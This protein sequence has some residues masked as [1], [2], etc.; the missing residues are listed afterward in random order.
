MAKQNTTSRTFGKCRIEEELGR[1]AAS[2]VY[3]GYHESFQ[4]PVAV[5]VV[6]KKEV[7][8]GGENSSWRIMREAR[9]A[10]Q[11]THPHIVRIYDCG[12]T[13]EKFYLAMEYI[14]GETC[15]SKLDR[16]GPFPW[17][18]AVEL[19]LQ[20]IDGLRHALRKNIIH[21]DIK[22]ENIMLDTEGQ[23][24]IAD[25]G[26]AKEWMPG[27]ASGTVQGEVLGTPY[28]MSPEQVRTPG[29]VDF[30]SDVY[31]IGA[32][33]YH[34]VT[35][36]PPFE[37]DSPFQVMTKQ[38]SMPSPS[39]KERNPDLPDPLCRIIMRM[40]AKAPED[41]YQSYG[42]L[43]RDL[44]RLL[45]GN[46]QDDEAKGDSAPSI[47][48]VRAG[49]VPVAKAN[50]RAKAM[51]LGALMTYAVFITYL[52]H[53][54]YVRTGLA[55]A[56]AGIVVLLAISAAWSCLALWDGEEYGEDAEL[57]DSFRTKV[58]GALNSLCDSLFLPTPRVYIPSR[59][60]NAHFSYS[61]FSP[62]ASLD[63]P[64]KW[65][66]ETGIEA[67]ELRALLAQSL[68]G[69]VSGDSHLRTLLALPLEAVKIG[70]SLTWKLAGFLP[71]SSTWR[72][73]VARVAA[74][75]ACAALLGGIGLLFW[76]HMSAG[77]LASLVIGVVLLCA[78]FERA[79]RHG[80]DAFAAQVL[81]GPQLV[82]FVIGASTPE[83]EQMEYVRYYLGET[84]LEEISDEMISE[85]IPAEE[86]EAEEEEEESAEAED[87]SETEPGS[88][89]SAAGK[90]SFVFSKNA[91]HASILDR[92][93]VLFSP[94][95]LAPERVNRL[96]GMGETR[97]PFES[98]LRPI[99]H[100][101][102]SRLSPGKDKQ[103]MKLDDLG[104]VRFYAIL[105]S[106]VGIIAAVVL[107]AI[108]RLSAPHYA[109]LLTANAVLAGVFGVSLAG[110]AYGTN[111]SP[112]RFVW[113]SAVTS[114]FFACVSA[115]MLCMLGGQASGLAAIQVPVSFAM[116]SIGS[117][118]SG[119]ALTRVFS[120]PATDTRSESEELLS[121]I[122]HMK[123]R[124][125]DGKKSAKN[126]DEKE[127]KTREKKST[128]KKARKTTGK[129]QGKTSARKV[130]ATQGRAPAARGMESA[131]RKSG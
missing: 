57:T 44:V 29:E 79:S 116:V 10:A 38:V 60:D 58:Q 33:L 37:G 86:V 115:L 96:S 76:V 89:T 81:G 28:Y 85:E 62:K 27:R 52:Y 122:S 21:R 72:V 66:K 97:L 7:E 102:K 114:A 54:L 99:W 129:K 100:V 46:T 106:T 12:E 64:S 128:G 42:K 127:S 4:I 105:G 49:Q 36:S 15:R 3:R 94:L 111:I 32:T 19:V 35:G 8:R 68:G 24:R 55:G 98:L 95:P 88:E 17:R 30:R 91:Y 112:V 43:K 45:S 23:A 87:E 119:I 1:G 103:S 73:T 48:R 90:L 65:F 104:A 47:R 107:A 2:V 9:I 67:Y 6:P 40:M 80:E 26:L 101:I 5:K 130:K 125:S 39:P 70:R 31:A 51:G 11:L 126:S 75:V 118:F 13:G 25:L 113:N 34:F 69:V 53:F 110:Q 84:N 78:A 77:V 63:I 108:F 61:F 20:V 131:K 71:R 74:F 59:S 22:P 92:L 50:M 16:E 93:R 121:Q 123:K 56:L 124:K 14:E 18:L 120:H 109:V 83:G 82:K 117:F 41:R